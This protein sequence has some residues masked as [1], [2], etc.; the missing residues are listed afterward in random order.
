MSVV[1]ALLSIIL[2][3]AF[4]SAGVQ[5]IVFNPTM[6][7]AADHLGFTKRAYQRIGGLEVIGAIA[8]LIDLAAKGSSILA[9][10]N[11]VAAAAFIVLMLLA[12]MTHLRKGDGAKFFTP[13]LVLGV[14][15]LVELIARFL[16]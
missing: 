1:A 5:K 13:A 15:S 11:E 16:A 2:F 12:V 4:G 14:V 7:H 10:L 6:S 3:L 8:L 9:I